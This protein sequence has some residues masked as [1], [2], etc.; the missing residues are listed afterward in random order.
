MGEIPPVEPGD[1]YCFHSLEIARN[2]FHFPSF[3]FFHFE[4]QGGKEQETGNR[5]DKKV[6]P[7]RAKRILHEHKT[8]Y[9]YCVFPLRI[10]R[11][12]RTPFY[13]ITVL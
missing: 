2:S 7:N 8:E 6:C 4:F 12:A 10:T 9:G 11:N 3:F 5:E 13:T 1:I